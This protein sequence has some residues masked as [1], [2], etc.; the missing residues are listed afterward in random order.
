[1]EWSEEIIAQLKDLW[2]EGLS[3]AEIGR[4]L[5]ITKNA[6]VG[7]AHRLGLPPRPSPIRRNGSKP[8]TAA[9]K[10]ELPTAATPT[11]EVPATRTATTLP[12]ATPATQPLATATPAPVAAP[13][14]SPAATPTSAVIDDK[15]VRKEKAAPVVRAAAKP[16]TLL[17]SIS[18]PEPQKRRGPSCCWPIGDPGT[19]GFHF[20]GATPIPGKPYCEEHAQIAYVRLRDRRDSVA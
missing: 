4:R 12:S 9:D 19:P 15:A 1:M 2:A 7:K 17:R 8:K 5:S 14:P 18:D 11:P 10:T 20:C 16:K 3:T 6:V 13:V